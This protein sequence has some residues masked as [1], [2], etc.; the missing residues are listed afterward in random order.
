MN[1][2]RRFCIVAFIVT[3]TLSAHCLDLTFRLEAGA[4]LSLPSQNEAAVA[5]DL[6]G[7]GGGFSVSADVN[8]LGF[9]AP[10][11]E[12]GFSVLPGLNTGYAFNV[13][14]GG[15]GIGAY[16]MPFPR[17]KVS[18]A[19][20]GGVGFTRSDLVPT[21]DAEPVTQLY[22]LPY[23]K[24][25]TAVGYRFSP[26][27]TLSGSLEFIQ[28]L[29]LSPAA[30]GSP[31]ALTDF[32]HGFSFSASAE[33]SSAA[34]GERKSGLT[35]EGSQEKSVF[36]LI[37][38]LYDGIPFAQ[39]KI[40]NTEQ[41]EVTDVRISF[42]MGK[43]TS[44]TRA[45]AGYP[46]LRRGQT[47]SIPVF[48]LFNDQLLTF[49]ESSKAQ[50]E[51]VVAYSLLGSP[52][53]ATIPLTVEIAHRNAFTWDDA[54]VI[55]AFVSPT[56]PAVLELSKYIAGLVRDRVR[57]GIDGD[58]Q[59][60]MGFFEG[61]RTAGVAFSEDPVTPYKSFHARKDQVD[62]LQY[63]YQ[64][65]EYTTG[66]CD[67]LAVAYAAML[68]ATN[69]DCALVPVDGEVCVAI[70]LGLT[71]AEVRST[72]V[73]QTMI[74]YHDDKPWI[75][76]AMSRLREGFMSAWRKGADT[77]NGLAAAKA[78][79]DFIL[80]SQAWKSHPPVAVPKVESKVTKPSENRVVLAFENEI[81]RY[82]DWEVQP[83]AERMQKE[84]TAGGT[85]RQHNS[86]G[87]LYARYGLLDKA[88]AEFTKAGDYLP[89]ITNLGNAALVKREWES[90][91]GYFRR[92]LSAQADNTTA[93]V[94]L[95]RAMYELDQFGE[96]D[97]LYSRLEALNPK[98]A[99]EYSYLASKMGG[100][101]ARAASAL[102]RGRTLWSDDA[103]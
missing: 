88:V 74:V 66:D 3:S 34:F 56:D 25:R 72:F 59:Y 38:S 45:L 15:G 91:A 85:P 96:S 65:L 94:G 37:F 64:T 26:V 17:L 55:A 90:A 46:I 33:L 99:G 67:D 97:A 75:P 41:A 100:D 10:S 42:Q 28:Y 19:A 86:L 13:F 101:A 63:P 6:Y 20:L 54:S 68:E 40:T 47:V 2:S 39:V 44:Q 79:P 62:Y 82:V 51:I 30:E 32:F 1:V 48:A 14:S 24:A 4:T 89:A 78:L 76:V 81:G 60:A 5:T 93:L 95:A 36:P 7:L 52:M 103:P 98:L 29:G 50:G 61:L 83:R 71:P 58:L 18:A 49:T 21:E 8:L 53:S 57:S 87:V 84:M 22:I 11:V 80:L 9:L 12:A 69:I 31:L 35:V 43:Y 23:W 102:D 70:P 77:L 16:W 73:D 27:F 92:V